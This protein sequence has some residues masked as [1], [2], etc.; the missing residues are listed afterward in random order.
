MN[1][2]IIASIASMPTRKNI[3]KRCIES[4]LPQ[5][6]LLNIYLN[7]YEVVPE[8]LIDKKIKIYDSI[9]YGDKADVG[10]FFPLYLQKY[11]GYIFTLDD[12]LLYP[13]NYVDVMV[14]KIEKYKRKNFI[15]V[16]G[17]ILPKN[18]L[19]SYYREKIGVHYA[20][21]LSSDTYVD[22][23]GTGTL[24]FHSQLYP[25]DINDFS[26]PFMTDI[27]LYNIA[28]KNHIPIVSIEREDFWLRS[29]LQT[30]DKDSIYARFSDDDSFVTNIVN[31][32]TYGN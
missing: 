7:G 20:K 14:H 21:K 19:T 17:N 22:V 30:P 8:F 32:I 24:A 3:L 10:K 4:I 28:N 26:K 31:S 27:W 18:R 15:C 5:V 23:P 16:H 13:S 9:Q 2:L 11:K 12:D 29:L 25:V 6:D 1:E